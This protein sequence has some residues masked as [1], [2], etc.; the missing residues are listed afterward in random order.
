MFTCIYCV[1]CCLYCVFCIVLFMYMFSYLF[2]PHCHRVTTQLQLLVVVVV[3]M[4]KNVKS[5]G[6][7]RETTHSCWSNQIII[8]YTQPKSGFCVTGYSLKYQTDIYY[9]I[10]QQP[11][12]VMPKLIDICVSVL[13]LHHPQCH[14]TPV[15]SSTHCPS[16][17]LPVFT[18][19]LLH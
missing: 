17:T 13:M 6:K 10:Y 11:I 12:F 7:H 2:Y 3:V 5:V 16:P 4:K 8:I 18:F 15:H 14:S 9:G 1:L 19:V